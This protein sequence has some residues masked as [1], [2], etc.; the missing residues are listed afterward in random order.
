MSNS[1]L[2][3]PKQV[4]PVVAKIVLIAISVFIAYR[5]AVYS[6]KVFYWLA[7]FVILAIV[8]FNLY[9][10]LAKKVFKKCPNCSEP[11][12]DYYQTIKFKG[13]KDID[14]G[15][16]YEAI[17]LI[18]YDCPKCDVSYFQL[19]MAN[20]SYGVGKLSPINKMRPDL[21]ESLVA[22]VKIEK[23]ISKEE[24]R[25]IVNELTAMVNRNNNNAGFSKSDKDIDLTKTKK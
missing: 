7:V 14:T 8:F 25:G 20:T 6:L 12:E 5:L 10:M 13:A 17:A 2:N 9:R 16:T 1:K 22:K 19:R 21:N 11:L 24:Y 15:E 3:A 4:N 23:K 18:R